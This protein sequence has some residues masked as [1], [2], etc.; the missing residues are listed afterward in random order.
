M[1]VLEVADLHASYARRPVLN[2]IDVRI[3]AG[4]WFCLLG[5]NGVGKSTL[6][7][8]LATRINP[9]KGTIRIAD[10]DLH[11]SPEDAKRALGFACA[12][13]QLPQL[14]TGR[15]CLEVFAAAKQRDVIDADVLA[16]A[17]LLRLTPYLNQYVDTYSLGTRQ[18]LCVLLA[19]LSEPKLIVLDE[20]FNGLDPRSALILKH[21]LKRRLHRESAVL[22]ATHSLDIVEHHADRAALMMSGHIVREWSAQELRGM[23]KR[24]QDFE[25]MLAEASE[26]LN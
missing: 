5:P 9:T 16:L 13:E 24:G 2:G 26:T 14:L 8:C 22:L 25:A 12:P 11:R 10:V 17:E 3:E 20:A 7:H 15:Q 18:K 1:F 6:L 21:E 19:L 23:R 4:E